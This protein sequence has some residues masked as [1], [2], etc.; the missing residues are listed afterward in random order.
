MDGSVDVFSWLVWLGWSD[1]LGQVGSQT[2]RI[3]CLE[4]YVLGLSQGLVAGAV[5]WPFVKSACAVGLWHWFGRFAQWLGWMEEDS[6][7]V[8][9]FAV[10]MHQEADFKQ[11]LTSPKPTQAASR[12]LR[13]E[14]FHMPAHIVSSSKPFFFF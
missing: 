13:P 7:Y 6:R 1:C 11:S 9:A 3:G 8:W 14:T 2:G 10:A 5:L 12:P 4:V